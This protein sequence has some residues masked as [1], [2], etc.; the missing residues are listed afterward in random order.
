MFELNVS[1]EVFRV[2]VRTSACFT[3]VGS[4]VVDQMSVDVASHRLLVGQNFWTERTLATV[5][6]Q[7]VDVSWVDDDILPNATCVVLGFLVL[8]LKCVE[9]FCQTLC[10]G[11]VG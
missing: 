10:F 1:S 9:E 6:S 5:H 11:G 4:F 8:L 3:T 7:I 2:A